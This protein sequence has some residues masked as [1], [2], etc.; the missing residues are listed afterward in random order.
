MPAIKDGDWEL[1]EY[2]PHLKRSLWSYF[3]GKQTHFRTTQETD[4]IVRANRA[5][6]NLTAGQRWGEWRKVAS[7]PI[8]LFYDNLGVAVQNRDEN[9]INKFLND[10][11][12]RDFRTFLGRV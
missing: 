7:I 11:D 10:S 4:D 12:N 8:N 9:Y 6:Q 5:E 3:D 1:I 2:Q